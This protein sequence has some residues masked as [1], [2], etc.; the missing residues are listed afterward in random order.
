MKCCEC[1][2]KLS[3]SLENREV[4]VGHYRYNEEDYCMECWEIKNIKGISGR[5]PK[6][7]KENVDGK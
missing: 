2:R 7:N 3:Y 5:Y 1:D 6:V 4:V